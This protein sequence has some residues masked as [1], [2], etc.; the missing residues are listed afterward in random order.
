VHETLIIESMS[1][2][3]RPA[4]GDG[5]PRHALAQIEAGPNIEV[6]AFFQGRLAVDQLLAEDRKTLLELGVLEDA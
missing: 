3:V 2:G 5:G 1:C 4:R 6:V